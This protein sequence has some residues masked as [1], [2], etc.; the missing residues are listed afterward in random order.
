[1]IHI[2]EQVTLYCTSG[3]HNKLYNLGIIEE[4]GYFSVVFA[5]GPIGGW[6]K[7]GVK[8][9]NTNRAHAYNIYHGILNEKLAK[10]YHKGPHE[11]LGVTGIINEAAKKASPSEE[12]DTKAAPAVTTV[13]AA[14]PSLPC[15]LLNPVTE[16]EVLV[17]LQDD[18]YCAQE[19][20]DGKRMQL[21]YKDGAVI[22]YNRR[23]KECGC[24]VVYRAALTDIAN[25]SGIHDFLLD[26][27][28]V[29]DDYYAFDI[30]I[31]EGSDVCWQGYSSRY[32]KLESLV[33]SVESMTIHL[34]G[35]A[36]TLAQKKE[37]VTR[38][39]ETEREGVVFKRLDAVYTDGRPSSGGDQL[40]YKFYATASCRVTAINTKRSVSLAVYDGSACV[41][42]GNCTIPPNRDI[43]SKEDIVEIR[44]LYAY[45]GGS[46]YQPTYLGVRDDL[47]QEDCSISQ[48]K[49]K[50]AA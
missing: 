3:K 35:S 6:R 38:L 40:K 23:H 46:L 8:V 31:H 36:Y 10:G 43:P 50:K 12:V 5:Y 28:Q 22:A 13:E 30:L 32:S 39:I 44:Y 14:K 33:S 4:D 29:G 11:A 24:P 34:V 47:T 49:Y 16:D 20:H 7:S 48:L 26:G 41:P 45:K 21:R 25:H 2:L 37:L 18:N 42:V 17:L 19:K 9:E 27:E 1:M 15:Q